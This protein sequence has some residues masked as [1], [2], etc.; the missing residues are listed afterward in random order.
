MLSYNSRYYLP[1]LV[2]KGCYHT[3]RIRNSRLFW[4]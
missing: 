4:V 1:E 2:D 3:N